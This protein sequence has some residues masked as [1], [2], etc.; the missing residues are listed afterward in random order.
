MRKKQ[1]IINAVLNTKSNEW[2]SICLA[3]F[4][5]FFLHAGL[6][7]G[8]TVLTAIFVARF[9]VE[10]L[11][12]LFIFNS[13][14]IIGG[15]YYFSKLIG[16]FSLTD[17]MNFTILLG[18]LLLGAA[19]ILHTVNDILFVALIVIA[20][21]VFIAQL[22]IF[23]FAFTE[24]LF[25]PIEGERVF[26]IIESGELL[27][28]LSGAILIT[29]LASY[30]SPFKILYFW[31][32]SLFLIAC[33][34]RVFPGKAESLPRIY[35]R[36][37]KKSHTYKQICQT[38]KHVRKVSFLKNLFYIVAFYWILQNL[39][40]FQFTHYIAENVS[41]TL[42]SGQ[43]FEAKLTHDIGTLET[44]FHGSALVI[45]LFI[46]SRVISGIG[47]IK[48]FIIRPVLLIIS[49]FSLII[50]PRF[51]VAVLARNNLE[52]GNIMHLNAYHNS[53]YVIKHNIRDHVREFLEGYIKPIG[54]IIG[55]L[56]IIILEQFLISGQVVFAINFLVLGVSGASFWLIS[57]TQKAYTKLTRQHLMSD[58]SSA[59]KKDAIEILMQKGHHHSLKPLFIKD[60]IGIL[61]NEKERD[62]LK[63]KA[64]K[65]LKS[66]RDIKSISAVIHCLNSK[67][68]AVRREAVEVLSLFE[69]KQLAKTSK[70]GITKYLI[71][72]VKNEKERSIRI[73]II[74]VLLK[75]DHK[76][77]VT[78]LSDRLKNKDSFIPD[79][80]YAA[81]LAKSKKLNK[82]IQNYLNSADP[83]IKANSLV[84]LWGI[85][86]YEIDLKKL[87]NQFLRPRNRE[88]LKQ[89]LFILSKIKVS[90]S[91]RYLLPHIKS[92]N[93]EIKLM[94]AYALAKENHK[95][96]IKPLAE[97]LCSKDSRIHHE[98]KS[99]IQTLSANM[100]NKI[101]REVKYQLSQKI[102]DLIIKAKVKFLEDLPS[103]ALLQLKHAYTIVEEHSALMDIESLIN[104]KTNNSTKPN[105]YNPEEC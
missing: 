13:A 94:A 61:K 104:Q 73:A 97:L 16:R 20:Q 42:K 31:I 46:A 14:L 89:M 82:Q 65:V 84:A 21:A 105:I 66:Y 71:R 9:G 100:Q 10:H 55:T 38:I 88:V 50:A 54:I 52:I 2:P 72:I 78:F 85:K 90:S 44:L 59:T 33:I 4:L 87:L 24:E 28:G 80:I 41:A 32:I 69:K 102:R 74:R 39:I 98:T 57:K 51:A 63:V 47:T 56:I 96:A 37:L 36:K 103:A 79:Y 26:P 1:T 8:S 67:S 64:L 76:K 77:T 70:E 75:F 60:L 95:E 22:E 91:P 15:T 25:S 18:A 6:I 92:E 93:P 19:S 11:P 40:Q 34:V 7:V 12:Y 81:G 99:K 45:Q 48:S 43:S 53:Y 30:F 101:N 62:D 5:R 27:G 23:I 35:R 58:H 17:L 83:K 3:W 49:A 29:N 68:H 86:K